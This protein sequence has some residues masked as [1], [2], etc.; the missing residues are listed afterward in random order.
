M[1]E[2]RKGEKNNF[3]GRKH[4]EETKK[5]LSGP[6]SE[7]I[8]KKLSLANK[9]KPA[10]FKGRTH[11]IYSKM[12]MRKSHIRRLRNS[13]I[14][15][16]NVNSKE[17]EYFTNKEKELGLDGKFFGKNGT[18]SQHFVEELG[19]YLDFYDEKNNVVIEY[20][21]TG[22]Y[23]VNW[24]LKNKDVVRQELIKEHLKCKFYRFNEKL[25]EF[26]EV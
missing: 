18:T 21:E 4:T 7:E 2:N 13:G 26:Y 19:Y 12:K 22:H 20:D 23:D 25:N 10:P 1:R 11:T 24:N 16:P 8:K 5:K 9:G 14:F 6:K 17:T 3:Y 15:S